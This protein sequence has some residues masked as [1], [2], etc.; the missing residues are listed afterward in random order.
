VQVAAATRICDEAQ[1]NLCA[2]AFPWGRG[3]SGTLAGRAQFIEKIPVGTSRG[4]PL[5]YRRA[6]DGKFTLYSVL[7]RNG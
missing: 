3:K 2:G 6:A 1:I 7:E 4:G 5:K